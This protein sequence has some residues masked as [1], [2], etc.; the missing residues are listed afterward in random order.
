LAIRYSFAC[1]EAESTPRLVQVHAG[2][3]QELAPRA[4]AGDERDGAARHTK[5][6]GDEPQQ[7]VVGAALLGGSRESDAQSPVGDLAD[8]TAARARGDP[9]G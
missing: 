9:D 7:L 5:R 2:Q 1:S 4:P 3:S 8:L 6:V